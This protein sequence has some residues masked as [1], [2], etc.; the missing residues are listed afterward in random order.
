M[1]LKNLEIINLIENKKQW[2]VKNNSLI[3]NKYSENYMD[4]DPEI[5]MYLK[6]S[7]SMSFSEFQDIFYES[8]L[9][10]I[11]NKSFQLYVKNK[12]DYFNYSMGERRITEVNYFFLVKK[13][14]VM[15]LI[16]TIEEIETFSEME[17][18]IQGEKNITFLNKRIPM[19]DDLKKI[20]FHNLP[21]EIKK[22]LLDTLINKN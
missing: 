21:Y 20:T 19:K 12:E 13:S 18:G 5:D 1:G 16:G 9:S 11:I 8:E 2:F 10:K 4:A 15:Y 6:P 17:A 22:Y 14:K 3:I 7:D